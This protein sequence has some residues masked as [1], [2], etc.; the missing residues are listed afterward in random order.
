MPSSKG[1][2]YPRKPLSSDVKRIKDTGSVVVLFHG[3][4]PSYVRVGQALVRCYLYKKQEE[5]CSKCT[6]FGRRADV[7]P[8][9]M[10]NV[11][12]NSGAKDLKQGHSCEIR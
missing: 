10:V 8:T 11:C 1:F 2:S 7:C 4:V 9:P 6:H 12:H 3:D 5:V